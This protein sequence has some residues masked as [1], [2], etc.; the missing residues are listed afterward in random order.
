MRYLV[1]IVD[2]RFNP[3][4]VDPME[5]PEMLKAIITCGVVTIPLLLA[6]PNIEAKEPDALA[7]RYT[8]NWK[9]APIPKKCFKI[10]N[11]LLSEFRSK[12]YACDLTEKSDSASGEAFVQCTKTDDTAQYLIFKKAESCEKER[13]TQEANGDG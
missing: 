9:T 13:R 2:S 11:K 7:G 5:G 1:R 8:F 6:A 3:G 12:A 10:D 4:P